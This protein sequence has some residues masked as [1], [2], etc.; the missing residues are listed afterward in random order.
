MVSWASRSA[1]SSV[2]SAL[3]TTFAYLKYD[4]GN[5]TYLSLSSLAFL[6]TMPC[7]WVTVFVMSRSRSIPCKSVTSKLSSSCKVRG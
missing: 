1:L 2:L 3:D 7:R 4:T 5:T 6:V